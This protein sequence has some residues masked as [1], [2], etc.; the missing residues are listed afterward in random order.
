MYG[1]LGEVPLQLAELRGGIERDEDWARRP[2]VPA[3]IVSTVDQVGSRLLFR[4][5]GLSAGM[6]PVHAGLLGND[7][8]FVLDEVHLAHF[9]LQLTAASL[10]FPQPGPLR[11]FQRRLVLSMRLPIGLN[12]VPQSGLADSDLARYLCD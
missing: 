7:V 6:R 9:H 5:Y 12:P 11:Q 1:G 8:L 4:G 2:D 3:I 10:E